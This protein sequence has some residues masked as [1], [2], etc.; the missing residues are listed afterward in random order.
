M[1]SR[2]VNFVLLVSLVLLVESGYSLNLDKVKADF[3]KG[4]Y[5]QAIL[6]GEKILANTQPHSQH[7]DE[8]Y[9]I[10]GLSYLKDGNFLRASDIFEIIF[11]EF[12]DSAFEEEAKLGLGDTYFLQ[13][14]YTQSQRYY[15]DLI[16]SKLK[17][18]V[19]YRLSQCAVKLGDSQV[20][21]EY[22]DKLK[23]E[24]PLSLETRL[25]QELYP[26]SDI[27]YTVQVGCFSRATNA[28][29]L[30]QK[31]TQ[32]GYPAYIEEINTHGKLN[33]RVRA[34]KFSLIQEAKETARKLSQEGYPTKVFP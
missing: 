27:Y 28:Q 16:N 23:Q 9:Y 21:K 32:K 17:A 15:Q 14:N 33:Y 19:Y 24:F 10:L 34:G 13:G 31:L 22:L 20:A 4:D 7:L 2:I 11:N 3:L 12:K 5:K 6:E 1:P 30:V 18:A 25:Q 8:L 29:N 26:P